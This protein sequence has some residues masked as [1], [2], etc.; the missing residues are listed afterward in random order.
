MDY[1][2]MKPGEDTK[3]VDK[4]IKNKLCSP[5]IDESDCFQL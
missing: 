2:F 3:Y 1:K 5:W 4:D